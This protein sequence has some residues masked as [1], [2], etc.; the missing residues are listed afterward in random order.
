MI[1]VNDGSIRLGYNGVAWAFSHSNSDVYT[2]EA[3]KIKRKLMPFKGECIQAAKEISL[4]FPGKPIYVLYSGGIDSEAVLHSFV[5]AGLPVTAVC[6]KFE[7]GYNEHELKYAHQYLQNLPAEN[8]V[9]V[10]IIDFKIKEWLTSRECLDLAGTAQTVELGYTHLFKVALEHLQ[11]GVTITGHEEPLVHRHDAGELGRRWMFHCH[12][13]H[14]SIH[15]FFIANGQDSVPS[16][17]QWSS[18]LLNSFMH[19]QHWLALFNNLYPPNIWNTEQLK[20]G[21]LGS[22]MGLKPRKKYTSFERI[23]TEILDADDSWGAGLPV[24]WGRSVDVEIHK[25]Y[26]DHDVRTYFARGSVNA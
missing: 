4:A 9:T 22:S 14:Y 8:Q 19:N 13:R 15:K 18:E 5:E 24:V 3:D 11:D 10:K 20:Y 2:F 7:N 16:F 26:K 17:F 25:W 23:V 1:Q 6:I 12:E 21:F